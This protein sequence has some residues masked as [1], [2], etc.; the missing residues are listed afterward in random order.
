MGPRTPVSAI[1]HTVLHKG[2]GPT[3]VPRKEDPET[4]GSKG[5]VLNLY[6]LQ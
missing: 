4:T 2:D 3:H 1:G 5:G 6:D